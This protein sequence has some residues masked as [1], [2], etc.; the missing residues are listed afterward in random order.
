MQYIFIFVP[1]NLLESCTFNISHFRVYYLLRFI[2]YAV[3]YISLSEIYSVFVLGNRHFQFCD[4]RPTTRWRLEL[5][6]FVCLLYELGHYGWH[7]LRIWCIF[8]GVLVILPYRHR[9]NFVGEFSIKWS[10]HGNRWVTLF[11]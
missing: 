8:P 1:T 3:K 6:G 2:R 9:N 10:L 4:E 5:G 11:R 7:Y